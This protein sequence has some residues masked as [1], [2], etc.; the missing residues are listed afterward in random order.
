MVQELPGSS[1]SLALGKE[2]TIGRLVVFY[3]GLS[4]PRKTAG[5]QDQAKAHGSF[6]GAGYGVQNDFMYY[7]VW[8]LSCQLASN[9]WSRTSSKASLF[10]PVAFEEVRPLSGQKHWQSSLCVEFLFL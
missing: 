3:S 4:G 5:G 1:W 2:H 8:S 9:L 7:T 10:C 6:K